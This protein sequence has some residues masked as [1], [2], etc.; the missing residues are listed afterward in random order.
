MHRFFGWVLLL[1]FR[2]VL[3]HGLFYLRH[4][5]ELLARDAALLAGIGL[6]ETAI[7]RQVF[8]LNQSHFHTLEHDLLE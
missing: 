1:Q 7:D 5:R 8:A 3:A 2:Q 4:F 6:H